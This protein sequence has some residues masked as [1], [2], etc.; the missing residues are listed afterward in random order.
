[1]R[2]Q[3]TIAAL[4]AL[5]VL[6]VGS[7]ASAQTS[8][9][10]DRDRDDARRS[11]RTYAF[12][13]GD[14]SDRPRLGIS[15]GSS[16]RRDTLGV[17]VD[18][19]TPDS[20]AAKAGLE[21]GDRIVSI[22]GVNL[23]VAAVD[24]D[25]DEMS[26]VGA[27]R[28]TRQLTKHKAGD[29]VELRVLR[30]GNVRTLKVKTVAA[31]DLAST[32]SFFRE[33]R[34]EHE[35]RASLGI[36]LGSSGSK[37]DTLG[38]L[39]SSLVDEGPAA[40]AGME[41]GDRIAAIN[42]VDVRV[43]HDD[44]GDWESSSSR[45]R[46]LEREMGK[47]KAGDQVELKLYRGGQT[48]TVRVKTVAAKDLP[49]ESGSMFFFGDDAVG[50]GRAFRM[51]TPQIAPIPPVPP[52]PP[53]TPDVPSPPEPP[54][55]PSRLRGRTFYYDGM[56]PSEIRLRVNPEVEERVRAAMERAF[57]LQSRA[58]DT[59]SRIRSRIRTQIRTTPRPRIQLWS[60]LD[61]GAKRDNLGK[62]KIY[63]RTI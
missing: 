30:D 15:L 48:R 25:D 1:M 33:S 38:I 12:T 46:R 26:G 49:R 10:S 56:S 14:D 17:L 24:I 23:R 43:A 29:E 4:L 60:P 35:D 31:R 54:L 42:G 34:R 8:R 3:H 13:L 22:D 36:G 28:L 47:V 37:R 45:V 55:P 32:S 39:V 2:T 44:A 40:K 62:P 11:R 52:V 58:F 7:G 61:V 9:D 57:E 59:Q 21:E 27:R 19:V 41:E 6:S 16:G 50:G 51:L 53:M 5:S 18:A 20:P 63:L